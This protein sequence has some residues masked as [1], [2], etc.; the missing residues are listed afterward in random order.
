MTRRCFTRAA[1]VFLLTACAP[2]ITLPAP[3]E[4]DTPAPTASS[5]PPTSTL[6][7]SPSPVPTPSRRAEI[8]QVE[9]LALA[10]ASAA[11][12]FSVAAPG[13]TLPVGGEAQT[14]E[15]GRARLDLAPDGTIIRLAPN[16]HFALSKLD[17]EAGNP[18]TDLELFFGQLYIILSGGELQVQTPGGVASVRGSMMSVSYDP[19]AETMTVTCLEGHCSLRNEGGR[20]ELVAGQAADIVNGVLGRG[21]RDLT[22]GELYGWL[23]N[24]PEL[25]EFPDLLGGLRERIDKLPRRR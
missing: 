9:P 17:E 1:L 16:T 3:T 11:V 18:F 10:R 22:D 23:E 8:S 4:T 12:E 19:H 14:G 13:I 25:K 15:K 20:I 6:T 21:P 7:L 5:A 24:A 2:A